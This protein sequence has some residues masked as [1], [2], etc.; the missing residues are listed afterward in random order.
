[1]DKTFDKYNQILVFVR[2][3]IAARKVGAFN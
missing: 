2:K 1:M 3:T